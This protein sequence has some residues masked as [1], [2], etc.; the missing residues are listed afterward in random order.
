MTEAESTR[1]TPLQKFNKDLSSLDAGALDAA[2][3]EAMLDQVIS[4]HFIRSGS[5]SL[6]QTFS[7]E[8]TLPLPEATMTQFGEIFKI[9]QELK[10]GDVAPAIEWAD[11]HHLALRSRG[12]TLEYDLKRLHFIALVQ[13]G[14]VQDALTYARGDLVAFIPDHAKGKA[15][16]SERASCTYDRHSYSPT[17]QTLPDFSARCS[18][19]KA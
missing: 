11:R 5:F 12:S 15:E 16:R 8:S 13:G 7:D 1:L 3:S 17:L 14:K 18:S 4:L 2:D 9:L 6:A 10:R 19:P